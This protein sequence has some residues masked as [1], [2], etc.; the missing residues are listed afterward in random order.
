MI[1]SNSFERGPEGW[2]SYDYHASV[3]AGGQNIFILTTWRPDR[4]VGNGGYVWADQSRW[5]ADTPEKP[6]SILPL[7]HYRSWVNEDPVDLRD[8]ELAVYLRG[9]DLVLD[10]A[11]CYFWIHQAGT[12]W[13][14]NAHPIEISDGGWADQPQRLTLVDDPAQWYMSWT[15]T[16]NKPADLNQVMGAAASYGFSFVG[17]SNEVTGKLSLGGFE[18]VRHE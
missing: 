9:D 14:C 4:G 12:R 10:G 13:H 16:P 2:C 6:L 17:F 11:E 18:I 7:I 3:V 8:A 1:I 5:S 15:G